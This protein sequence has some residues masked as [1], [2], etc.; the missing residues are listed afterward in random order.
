MEGRGLAPIAVFPVG[1]KRM[2]YAREQFGHYGPEKQSPGAREIDGGETQGYPARVYVPLDSVA[3]GALSGLWYRE[4][5][6][7]A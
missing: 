4:C 5:H 6:E 3:V 7:V 2:G 1:L